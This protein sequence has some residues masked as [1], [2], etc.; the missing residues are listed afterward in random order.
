LLQTQSHSSPINL[1]NVYF[2]AYKQQ[3]VKIFKK[4]FYCGIINHGLLNGKVIEGT[5]PKLIS[6]ELFL[7]VNN[8]NISSPLYGVPHKKEREEVPLKVFMK[9]EDCG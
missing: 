5:H 8:I 3:L 6:E 1:R 2:K 9:C 7:E 4:P